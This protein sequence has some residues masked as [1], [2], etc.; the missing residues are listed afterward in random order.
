MTPEELERLAREAGLIQPTHQNPNPYA[1][2]SQTP[3]AE[4]IARF[5][6]LVRAQ[7]LEQA[8]QIAQA[9]VCA[10]HI[11]TGIAIHGAA[12]A[13]AIRALVAPQSPP[14]DRAEP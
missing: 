7:A 14:A 11:D 8:A 10:T 5:A 2:M 3:M 12:A 6:A 1:G 13:K 4:R 9:T